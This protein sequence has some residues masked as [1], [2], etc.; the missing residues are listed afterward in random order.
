IRRDRRRRRCPHRNR[1]VASGTG[2]GAAPQGMDGRG[3]SE[4]M[5]CAEA[6]IML[7]ALL[8]DEL[9]A[10]HALEVETHLATCPRCAAQL[11]AYRELQPAM[12]AAQL[13]FPAP[14]SL[15]RRIDA[16]LPSPPAH[17]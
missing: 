1:D 13:R 3:R 12:P 16:A 10:G 15:R 17:R 14:A 5:T 9:D 11:R 2:A 4:H 7:H 6:E 8:D